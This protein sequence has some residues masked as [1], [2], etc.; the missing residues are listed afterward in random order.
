MIKAMN[1]VRSIKADKLKS[2]ESYIYSVKHQMKLWT[3]YILLGIKAVSKI[4]A[5]Q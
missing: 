3:D 2:F 5:N 4:L 1:N